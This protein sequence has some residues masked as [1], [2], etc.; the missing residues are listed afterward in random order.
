MTPGK[1]FK[2]ID[3]ELAKYVCTAKIACKTCKNS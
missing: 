3:G 1:K 2:T